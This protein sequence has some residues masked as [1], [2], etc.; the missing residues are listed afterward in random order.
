LEILRVPHCVGIFGAGL[1]CVLSQFL[2]FT[3]SL[4]LSE[5]TGTPS[6]RSIGELLEYIEIAKHHRFP[7]KRKLDEAL[8]LNNWRNP[9]SNLKT[10]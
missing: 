1:A 5:R 6:Y 3:F 10:A 9:W 8:T 7:P 4:K 2:Q